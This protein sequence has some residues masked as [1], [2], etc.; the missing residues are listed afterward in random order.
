MIKN[1]MNTLFELKRIFFWTIRFFQKNFLFAHK[2]LTVIITFDFIIRDHQKK[3]RLISDLLDISLIFV[4]F[5]GPF[6]LIDENGDGNITRDEWQDKIEKAMNMVM[7]ITNVTLTEDYE[8]LYDDIWEAM[9]CDNA[10]TINLEV[11]LLKNSFRWIISYIFAFL[12]RTGKCFWM[13]KTNVVMILM[14]GFIFH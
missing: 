12:N 8:E 6:E 1:I 9:D 10:T 5:L 4:H 7:H 3:G 14:I 13:V 2:N 11:K